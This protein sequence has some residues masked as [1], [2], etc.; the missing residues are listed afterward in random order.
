MAITPAQSLELAAL[1]EPIF[2]EAE[3]S[4]MWIEDI[5]HGDVLSPK[6]L[7]SQQAKG[8]YV[9]GPSWWKLVARPDFLRHMGE[10]DTITL[11][12]HNAILRQRNA[13]KIEKLKSELRSLGVDV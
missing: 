11:E 6:Q 3:A 8:Q 2:V 7:R 10:S 4:G 12:E 9:L 1:M 5:Y 13:E